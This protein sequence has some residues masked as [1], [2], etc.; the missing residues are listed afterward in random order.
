M[1]FF[2]P[3]CN[4]EQEIKFQDKPSQDVYARNVVQFL[5]RTAVCQVCDAPVRSCFEEEFIMLTYICNDVRKREAL[6][7]KLGYIPGRPPKFEELDRETDK[8]FLE[9]LKQKEQELGLKVEL[10]NT[11]IKGVKNNEEK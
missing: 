8:K 11:H 10:V 3:N 6:R 5:R 4:K 9:E 2:C 1:K 7:A